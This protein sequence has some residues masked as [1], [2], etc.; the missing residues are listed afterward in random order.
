MHNPFSKDDAQES[1]ERLDRP[2]R[3]PLA[4][5]GRERAEIEWYIK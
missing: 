2:D 5:E 4:V 3:T 1:D